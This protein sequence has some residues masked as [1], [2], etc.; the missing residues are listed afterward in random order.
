MNSAMMFEHIRTKLS[1]RNIFVKYEV[2]LKKIAVEDTRNWLFCYFHAVVFFLLVSFH[3]FCYL[4]KHIDVTR[5]RPLK[6]F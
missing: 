3:Q 5:E 2:F 1:L 4:F 6:R